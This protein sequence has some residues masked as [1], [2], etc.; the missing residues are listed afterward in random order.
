MRTMK[1]MTLGL[2]LGVLALAPALSAQVISIADARQAPSGSLVTVEGAVTVAS[3]TYTSSTFDEGF[4]VQD[5]TAGIYVSSAFNSGL[6]LHQ[7]VRVTGTVGDDGFGQL[8]LR[9]AAPSDVVR[10]RGARRVSPD[11]VATADVGEATEG[12]LLAVR[13]TIT[14][15]VV[16]LPFGF[17]VFIND[18]SG[19]TQVF[20]AASTGI[21]PRAIPFMTVGRKIYAVGLSGQ[22]LAQNEVLPRNR[23]DLRPAH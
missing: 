14:R 20:I 4:A 18:G 2:A 15:I 16:D 10:L 19:E 12:S 6:D 22:F 7:R 17:Q 23:G 11:F 13:G 9:P 5:G 8:V 3:G 21:D 1:W